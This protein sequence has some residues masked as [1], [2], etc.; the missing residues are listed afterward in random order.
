MCGFDILMFLQKMTIRRLFFVTAIFQIKKA[1]LDG[2]TLESSMHLR[3]SR[4]HV[5]RCASIRAVDY[6]IG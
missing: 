1:K 2:P 4:K 6:D 5:H 3:N